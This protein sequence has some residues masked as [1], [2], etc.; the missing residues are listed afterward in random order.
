VQ[1]DSSL[2]VQISSQGPALE[3]GTPI[4]ER[5]NIKAINNNPFLIDFFMIFILML[6]EKKEFLVYHF[7][8]KE[9]I[10]SEKFYLFIFVTSPPFRDRW[11]TGQ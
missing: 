4:A 6:F 3:I 11:Y 10:V 9:T 2:G 7:T 8:G 5:T 1:V